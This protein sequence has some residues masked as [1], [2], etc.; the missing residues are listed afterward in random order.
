MKILFSIDTWGLVGGTERLTGAVVPGLVERGHAV[1]VLCRESSGKV[2]GAGLSRSAVHAIGFLNEPRLGRAERARLGSLVQGIAPDVI[3][4][5]SDCSPAALEVLVERAPL[6]RYVHSHPLFCPGLNKLHRDGTSCHEPLGT[7]C[8]VRYFAKG[9]CT[10]FN[11]TQYPARSL[12]R[13]A[14]PFRVLFAKYREL[15]INR[16][17]AR[18]LT[19]SDYMVGEL[20]Q[21][22]FAAEKVERIWPFTLSGTK[23]QA[24]AK[25]DARTKRFLDADARPVVL[26]PARLAHPDKGIDRLL[27]ALARVEAPHK[28]VIAGSGPDEA[29]LQAEAE[30]LGLG[31]DRVLWAGWQDAGAME[32]LLGR[33]DVV[34]CPSVWDEPFGLVGLEAMAHAKPVVAFAVGGIPEWLEHGRTGLLVER[35]D[36]A[37]LGAALERLLVDP[38][39]AAS[40]GRAGAERLAERFPREAHLDA[41][42]RA[43]SA[44]AAS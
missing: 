41:L 11:R 36:S 26:T 43:L 44:A 24:K 35:G 29:L 19:N 21:A 25:L 37:A 28:L 16:R 31:P 8:L 2:P 12:A 40:L 10:C 18:L 38:D 33:A 4:V 13:Y 27:A 32:T 5:Q 20:V 14:A 15:S 39:L 22:G 23:G 6:V 3:F 17:A 34:A 30:R 1:E 42:E 7:E 9:G